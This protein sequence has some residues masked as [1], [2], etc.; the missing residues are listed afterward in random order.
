MI[1]KFFICIIIISIIISVIIYR[2][3]G[4]IDYDTLHEL[5]KV[6]DVIEDVLHIQKSCCLKIDI[7]DITIYGSV[8]INDVVPM[9]GVISGYEHFFKEKVQIP[10][11]VP[12]EVERAKVNTKI[13]EEIENIKEIVNGALQKNLFGDYQPKTYRFQD[14]IEDF[15]NIQEERLYI[16]KFPIGFVKSQMRYSHKKIMKALKKECMQKYYDINITI[17]ESYLLIHF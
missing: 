16:K 4:H 10:L 8:K 12:D 7:N 3:N 2:L 5:E 13:I 15:K 17:G 1:L 14:L 11:Q 6:L 9:K